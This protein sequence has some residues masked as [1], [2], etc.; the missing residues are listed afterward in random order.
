MKTLNII[1]DNGFN[2]F[3]YNKYNLDFFVAKNFNVNVI[4]ISKLTRKKNFNKLNFEKPKNNNIHTFIISKFSDLINLYTYKLN[5]Y[6][7]IS[8]VDPERLSALRIKKFL[9][10]KNFIYGI[11]KLDTIYSKRYEDI[12]INSIKRNLLNKICHSLKIRGFQS[13]LEKLI[14]KLYIKFIF[15]DIYD[16]VLCTSIESLN[17]FD[18]Q[19]K[20]KDY[21]LCHHWDYNNFLLSE[22]LDVKLNN[23]IVF[24]DQNLPDHPES[25]DNNDL[26]L[27]TLNYYKL[28]NIFLNEVSSILKSKVHICLHPTTNKNN[29]ENYSK[30]FT[31]SSNSTV[32]DIKNASL[33]ISHN[34][35]ALNYAIIYKKPILFITMD[36]LKNSQFE[37]DIKNFAE[38]INQNVININKY[39]KKR[40]NFNFI[41]NINHERYNNYI[42]KN[43]SRIKSKTKNHEI[44]FNFFLEKNNG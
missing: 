19:I 13:T 8:L 5:N 41:E 44:I 7:I 22:N 10:K 28:L 15:S 20:Y 37:I 6:S 12:I 23:N 36:A 43:L 9:R 33:I 30:S 35:L 26:S 4:D 18:Y 38:S 31:F 39:D 40:A 34:S 11:D 17:K 42:I 16:F 14:S 25:V 2:Q 32:T 3:I 29:S 1:V 27:N 21:L 24:V